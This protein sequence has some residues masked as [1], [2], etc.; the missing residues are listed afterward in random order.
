[1]F[2]NYTAHSGTIQ[3]VLKL[4]SVFWNYTAHSGTIQRV[5]ELYSVFWNYTACLNRSAVFTLRYCERHIMND[6]R[7]SAR[8]TSE[9]DEN[10]IHNSG[11]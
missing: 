10:G 4:Y 1:M 6:E 11:R 5:L 8:C 3:R 7:G 9:T 2:W